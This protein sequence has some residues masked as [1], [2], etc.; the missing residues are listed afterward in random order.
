MLADQFVEAA[1]AARTTAALDN[2]ARLLWRAHGD[3]NLINWVSFSLPRCRGAAG[4]RWLDDG[5]V[6]R[7][8]N[9]EGLLGEAMKEQPAGR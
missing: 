4:T 9:G 3:Q 6:G 5:V 7:G 1:E 8:S 2:V